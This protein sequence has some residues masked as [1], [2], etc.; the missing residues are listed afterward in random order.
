MREA[1]VVLQLVGDIALSSDFIEGF[2]SDGLVA[3]VAE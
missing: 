3:A 2:K 1:M